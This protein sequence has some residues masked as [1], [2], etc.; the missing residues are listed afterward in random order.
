M[1]LFLNNVS[2]SS[3]QWAQDIYHILV[4]KG[5]K[6]DTDSLLEALTN[7]I[8][9]KEIEGLRTEL[10]FINK[11][12]PE[13]FK[14]DAEFYSVVTFATAVFAAEAEQKKSKKE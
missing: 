8:P 9:K 6:S 1:R 14:S 5:L 11:F 4:S 7:A 2:H 3:A 10:D 13:R 12:F